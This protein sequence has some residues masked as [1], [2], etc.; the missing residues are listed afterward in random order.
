MRTVK[1]PKITYISLNNKDSEG[2]IN[3]V[4]NRLFAKAYANLIAKKMIVSGGT[5]IPR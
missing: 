5:I 3:Q 4:Y 2:R 1:I